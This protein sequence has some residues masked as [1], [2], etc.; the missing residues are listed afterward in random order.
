METELEAKW[1]DIEPEALREKLREIG[2]KLIH[3]ERLMRRRVFD[4][5]DLRLDQHGAWLRVRDEGDRVTL[6]FKQWR[7]HSLH[8]TA[9]AEVTVSDFDVAAK[10]LQALGLQE[11]SYQETK[12]EEWR[13]G[14]VEIT[15]DTW[16]WI[17]T[18][19]E[20]EAPS[21]TEVREMADK[22]ELPWDHA[23]FGGVVRAYQHYYD[24][25]R[26]EIDRCP[27]ITFSPVPD[28]LAATSRLRGH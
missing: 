27:S 13:L 8:G 12:R 7:D 18:F 16:P 19:V 6:A 9:E 11:K 23:L 22:L 3:P 21:E 26:E 4:F 20:V 10:I 14:E 2:A 28:W 24:V 5:P 25:S 17:P 1:L 15:I